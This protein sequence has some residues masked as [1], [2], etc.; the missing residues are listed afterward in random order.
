MEEK[1]KSLFYHW[2]SLVLWKHR[3]HWHHPQ[4]LLKDVAFVHEQ[5]DSGVAKVLRV[6]NVLKNL[7]N[8]HG[9]QLF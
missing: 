6:A 1:C 5:N 2:V 4:L 7:E 9:I 3:S 8:K